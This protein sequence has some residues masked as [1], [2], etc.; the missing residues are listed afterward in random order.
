M[1]WTRVSAQRLQIH[2]DR[3]VKDVTPE[4]EALMRE[5]ACDAACQAVDRTLLAHGIDPENPLEFQKDM[6]HLREWRLRVER[7][8]DKSLMTIVVIVIGVTATI[9]GL[10]LKTKLGF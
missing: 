5:I 10:G 7:I 9:I 2:E 4:V 1:A 6:L 3:A 8:Q